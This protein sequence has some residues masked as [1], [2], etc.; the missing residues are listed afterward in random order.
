[1]LFTAEIPDDVEHLEA[2]IP[3][4]EPF[5]VPAGIPDVAIGEVPAA[6]VAVMMH[7][8]AYE[9]MV[10][11]YRTLGAWVP[12]TPPPAANASAS[13]TSSAPAIPKPPTPTVRRSPGRS[14]PSAL[15]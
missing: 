3:I 5:H 12:A 8:G 11:T 2:F 10:D 14:V 6:K 7:I 15:A 1:M 13:G 9:L 4:A